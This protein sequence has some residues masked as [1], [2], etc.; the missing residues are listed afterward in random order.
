[1]ETLLFFQQEVIPA[2]LKGLRVSIL[3]ILPS[4]VI[5]IVIGIV[6]GAL[7]V[8]GNRVTRL[9]ADTYVTL[10][11]GI[12]LVVQL[13]MW[14]FGLPYLNIYLNPFAASVIG[15]SLC[16]GA[17]HSEYVRGAFLSIKRGQLAAALALGFTRLQMV[18][19]I[20]LPQGFRRALPGCGNELIYLVKYSSLAYMIT[21]IELTGEA[22][23]LASMTFRYT[24]I[25]F[26]V[27][28]VY[29]VLVT[30]ASWLLRLLEDRFALPG[31]EH[32]KL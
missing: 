7:R 9:A 30:F 23:I 2:F 1:M 18:T 4:A 25:F 11:R 5:G 22:K 29:L 31:F 20:L 8:Y 10:F 27:G 19:A 16:S 17:Y 15:F 24:E 12:P 26:A 32:R 6:T 14:Y 3:L 28:L 13:F 21:C